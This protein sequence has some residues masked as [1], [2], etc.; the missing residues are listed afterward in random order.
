MAPKDR[1]GREYYKYAGLGFEFAALVGLFF[2][3]GHIA[4]LRWQCEPWG[5]MIGGGIG[6]VGGIYLLAKQG[7]RMMRELD[8]P[9]G[10]NGEES[11]RSD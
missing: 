1:N 2:Y 9:R 8:A 6:V 11:R 4:D 5:L 3:F 7:N 10:R